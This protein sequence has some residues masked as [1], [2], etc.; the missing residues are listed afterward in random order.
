MGI[1]SSFL[2]VLT[3]IAFRFEFFFPSA[4]RI[5]LNRRL[6]EYKKEGLIT[7]Y[8]VKASR[9][10]KYHYLLEID[11]SVNKLPLETKRR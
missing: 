4:M 8:K 5:F 7:G 2:N 6:G 3:R 9:K 10:H 11:L 1:R